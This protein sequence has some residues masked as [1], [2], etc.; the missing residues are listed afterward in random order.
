ME[1]SWLVIRTFN[2]REMDV[3]SFL[4]EN[5]LTY[6]IPMTYKEKVVKSEMKPRKVL[7]PVVHGYVFLQKTM[8]EDELRKLLTKCLIPLQLMKN[9]GD[10]KVSEISDREMTDFRLLCDPDYVKTPVEFMDAEETALKPGTE[11]EIVHDQFAGIRGKLHKS[12]R[13]YW[14]IKTVGGISVMLRISRWYCKPL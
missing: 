6:F 9:K 10:D 11:V 12:N 5:G 8:Q 4:K 3:G 7:T 2:R 1:N 14:F 13:K